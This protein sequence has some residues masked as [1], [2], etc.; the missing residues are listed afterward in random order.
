MQLGPGSGQF[1]PAGQQAL[2]ANIA[3]QSA[4]NAMSRDR[5]GQSF[6]PQQAEMTMALAEMER[7]ERRSER[8]ADREQFNMQ[9]AA[10]RED[11]ARSNALTQQRTQ[12]EVSSLNATTASQTAQTAQIESDRTAI[13]QAAEVFNRRREIAR[14]A[15]MEATRRSSL[16]PTQDAAMARQFEDE[17]EQLEQTMMRVGV[18][19]GRALGNITENLTTQRDQ[20]NKTLDSRNQL[21]NQMAMTLGPLLRRDL[22]LAEL[23]L[24]PDNQTN[25]FA[26]AGRR[27][28]QA[29]DQVSQYNPFTG[30]SAAGYNPAARKWEA[31]FG[32]T[33]TSDA[34]L[35]SQAN[36][37]AESQASS[38]RELL[39]S[40]T[41]GQSVPQEVE[42]AMSAYLK[43]FDP[44]TGAV[45]DSSEPAMKTLVGALQAAKMDPYIVGAALSRMATE[46]KSHAREKMEAFQGEVVL[47]S[48]IPRLGEFFRD[49]HLALD[50]AGGA[51]SDRG[52]NLIGTYNRSIAASKL[53]QNAAEAFFNPAFSGV[54]SNKRLEGMV[55]VL[56]EF[57]DAPQQSLGDVLIGNSQ[58]DSAWL[59]SDQRVSDLAS[60]YG[61]T[62]AD[63][64]PLRTARDDIADF[65][66][67]LRQDRTGFRDKTREM[68]SRQSTERL[69]VGSKRTADEIAAQEA[70]QQLLDNEL[71][72]VDAA[73]LAQLLALEGQ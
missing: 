70:L 44:I 49:E 40:L 2:Q 64:T 26:D 59:P 22:E 50:A 3:G 1:N 61:L 29:A 71:S 63:V 11:A 6:N 34:F 69:A 54:V 45:S 23:T 32:G 39:E 37:I 73:T 7:D 51:Y 57:E 20:Y 68:N 9:F 35:A 38:V 27:V 41:E 25:Q 46:F 4:M 58:F 66:E 53:A 48:N 8:A 55:K 5:R 19:R 31:V 56:A 12:A 47:G 18:E 42:D 72:G 52:G 62:E 17:L 21:E 15:A 28:L 33:P 13:E 10:S 65:D 14:K 36:G 43:T 60:L 67:L 30:F 16:A 24:V